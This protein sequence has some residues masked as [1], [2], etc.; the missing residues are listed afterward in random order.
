MSYVQTTGVTGPLLK[1][2]FN[3]AP[4]IMLTGAPNYVGPLV[5][6]RPHVIF[7][8]VAQQYF[9]VGLWRA[10]QTSDNPSSSY[11]NNLSGD[12]QVSN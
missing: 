2:T 9:L 4:F 8:L 12:R 7:N 6:T 1:T 3:A 11:S 10:G 5:D